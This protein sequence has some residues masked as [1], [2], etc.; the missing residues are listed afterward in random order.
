[1]SLVSHLLDRGLGRGTSEC[2]PLAQP[3]SFKNVQALN[4]HAGCVN[5]LAWSEADGGARLASVSDDCSL[6][7]R[8]WSAVPGPWAMRSVTHATG[9]VAN[10]FGVAWVPGCGPVSLATAGMDCQVRLHH[11]GSKPVSSLLFTHGDRVKAGKVD[12][13][14]RS[15]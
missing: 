9:H 7:V 5:R 2:L 4:E 11:L 6:V 1:M 13:L 14:E 3:R 12:T 8:E 15:L 10:I